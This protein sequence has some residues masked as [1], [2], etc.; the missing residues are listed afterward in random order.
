M[1]RTA[2]FQFALRLKRDD[3]NV[4][5]HLSVCGPHC[6]STLI[7]RPQALQPFIRCCASR[8]RLRGYLSHDLP[9]CSGS[10]S[11]GLSG[12]PPHGRASTMQL[13]VP[14]LDGAQVKLLLERRGPQPL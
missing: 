11:G 2:D 1:G 13:I 7:C 12:P 4:R 8:I 3:W 10:S 14:D 9:A 5:K 6:P